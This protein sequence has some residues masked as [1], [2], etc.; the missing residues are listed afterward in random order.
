MKQ[1]P[2]SKKSH[3]STC[4]VHQ[5]DSKLYHKLKYLG[6]YW[7]S[8]VSDTIQYA[9]KCYVCQIHEDFIHRLMESLHPMSI[10]WLF[11]AWSLDI[12]RPIS[13]SSSKGHI[14]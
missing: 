2:L 14:L 12:I 10:S 1:Y 6:Y 8:L 9:K 13:A 7:P 3:S 4:G 5:S 11:E